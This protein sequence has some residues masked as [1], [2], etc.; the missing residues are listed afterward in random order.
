MQQRLSCPPPSRRETRY[1][2]AERRE[3]GGW[4][5]KEKGT[6]KTLP[7]LVPI[8]QQLRRYNI[9]FWN[10]CSVIQQKYS[11]IPFGTLVVVAG[12][13]QKEGTI[14]TDQLGGGGGCWPQT[15]KRRLAWS[16][17][18]WQRAARIG[19]KWRYSEKEIF[20]CL[21]ASAQANPS[22]TAAQDGK[23]EKNSFFSLPPPFSGGWLRVVAKAWREGRKGGGE[24]TMEWRRRRWRRRRRRKWLRGSWGRKKIPQK[25]FRAKRSQRALMAV[26]NHLLEEEE[27]KVTWKGWSEGSLVLLLLLLLLGGNKDVGIGTQ[28]CAQSVLLASSANGSLSSLLRTSLQRWVR[29]SENAK[30]L[31]FFYFKLTEL[32][33]T[34][35]RRRRRRRRRRTSGYLDRCPLSS[36]EQFGE[37]SV[38]VDVMKGVLR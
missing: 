4:G 30:M 2:R 25:W 15:R 19:R 38:A 28:T 16:E 37:L 17:D 14:T 18:G 10:Y 31:F 11:L 27:R 21:M 23:A 12:D 34:R 29:P 6:L 33:R 20:C 7:L 3:G 9:Y 35:T 22:L 8:R 24:R 1:K 36:L 5:R 13:R 32:R 26:S